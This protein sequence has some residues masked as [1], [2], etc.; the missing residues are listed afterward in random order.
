[1]KPEFFILFY[2]TNKQTKTKQFKSVASPPCLFLLLLLL[3]R[4]HPSSDRT[5][6][7]SSSCCLT[8][9]NP[10]IT[11]ESQ[12]LCTPIYYC[13]PIRAKTYWIRTRIVLRTQEKDPTAEYYRPHPSALGLVALQI[14]TPLNQL[15]FY[16]KKV[17]NAMKFNVNNN[18]RNPL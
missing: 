8:R 14:Y 11:L 7:R 6:V 5:A 18:Y 9:T 4:S 10:T 1:M 2:K 13:Q 16:I 15:V 3:P 17:Q 12:W